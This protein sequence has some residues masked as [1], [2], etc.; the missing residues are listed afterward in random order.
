M[1]CTLAVDTATEF[2]SVALADDTGIRAVHRALPRAHNRHLLQFVR[3]LLADRDV[4]A[5]DTL[6]CGVGP[7]SFTGLRIAVGMMQGLGWAL[8]RPV[9]PFCSLW[10]QLLD[11]LQQS[12]DDLPDCVISSIDAQIGQVYW[13]GFQRSETGWRPL[14]EAELSDG[15]PIDLGM[16]GIDVALIGSGAAGLSLIDNPVV[17]T[18]AAARPRAALMTLAPLPPARVANEL[19]PTYVQTEIGWKTL[20]EQGNHG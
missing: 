9:H 10:A 3:E 7:G 4:S 8:D 16:P 2:C 13:R 20:R 11:A 18:A 5:V 1:K 12:P 17:F 19:M 6:V 15:T 14:G